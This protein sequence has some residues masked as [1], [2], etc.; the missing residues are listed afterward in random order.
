MISGEGGGDDDETDGDDGDGDGDGDDD[1]DNGNGGYNDDDDDSDD[2]DDEDA[3]GDDD[4]DNDDDDDDDGDDYDDAHDDCD[5]R[6]YTGCL[7][8]SHKVCQERSRKT[9][10]LTIGAPRGEAGVGPLISSSTK[11]TA[12]AEVLGEL[13][14]RTLKSTRRTWKIGFVRHVKEI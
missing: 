7:S 14:P 5:V 4:D 8:I 2:D 1:D 6:V 11:R 10:P 12:P 3:D 13:L 9:G